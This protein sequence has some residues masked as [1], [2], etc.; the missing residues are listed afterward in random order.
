MKSFKNTL[1][2][3]AVL[4]VPAIN[5]KR[6]TSKPTSATQKQIQQKKQA[7]E[8][9]SERRQEQA[10]EKTFSN[11]MAE[12]K[13]K[14]KPDQVINNREF[15]PQFINFVKNA[16]LDYD[17]AKQ[18]LEAGRNLHTKWSGNEIDDIA[19]L[20]S[21]NRQIEAILSNMNEESLSGAERVNAPASQPITRPAKSLPTPPK[22]TLSVNSPEVQKY[23]TNKLKEIS[24]VSKLH[25]KRTIFQIVDDASGKFHLSNIDLDKAIKPLVDKR[26]QEI[27]TSKNQASRT[28][29]KKALPTPTYHTETELPMHQ[30]NL[31]NTNLELKPKK[32]AVPSWYDTETNLFTQ[33]F[34]TQSI[35]NQGTIANWKKPSNWNLKDLSQK[36]GLAIAPV[37]KILSVDIENWAVEYKKHT[38]QTP[39]KDSVGRYADI[40]EQ[41][42]QYLN[43]NATEL[44]L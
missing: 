40:S 26:A 31:G 43:D 25:D 36:I 38:K 22:K 13:T 14:W 24:T 23:L 16:N 39:G 29:T 10:E 11:Y 42:R 15:T 2:A 9:Q 33:E 19:L 20:Q 37:Y 21:T 4:A 28:Q 5:A 41:I 32:Q 30:I 8:Q 27:A 34:L 18:L 7:A 1:A 3:F 12:V 6:E 44:G 35:M 17:L